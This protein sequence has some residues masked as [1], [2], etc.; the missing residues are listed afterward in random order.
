MVT[1]NFNHQS[2]SSV[3]GYKNEQAI[4]MKFEGSD[5][6]EVVNFPY[7]LQRRL[8]QPKRRTEFT[9]SRDYVNFAILTA[10][11]WPLIICDSFLMSD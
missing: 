2:L 8:C 4:K 11:L 7:L 9:P 3:T 10:I 5:N 1:I 6:L